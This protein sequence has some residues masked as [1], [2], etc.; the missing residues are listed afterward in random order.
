[1]NIPKMKKTAVF[2][3]SHNG[4]NDYLAHRI[5]SDL[6]CPIEEIEPLWNVQFF[7]LFGLHLGNKRIS[8]DLSEIERII[9]VGPIWMGKVIAPLKSFINKYKNQVDEW[10]FTTCCGSGFEKKNDKFGHALVFNKIEELL[11]DQC[12][13]C[14]AFPV[15]LVLPEDQREDGK[16]VMET[17]LSEDNFEG[18]ILKIYELYLE[19]LKG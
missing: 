13:H 17:R 1:M 12:S 7:L 19:K 15:T 3:Y 9:L 8:T 6:K 14:E 5:A 11:G 16:L 10:V 4:S 18:E 2:Y